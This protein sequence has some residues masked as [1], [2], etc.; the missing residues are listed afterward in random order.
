[1]CLDNL[2]T[3]TK[4]RRAPQPAQDGP[5]RR[6]LLVR[7]RGDQELAGA[8]QKGLKR[9]KSWGEGEKWKKGEKKK[10]KAAPSFF[11]IRLSSALLSY[12][13]ISL[14]PKRS[15]VRQQSHKNTHTKI[16]CKISSPLV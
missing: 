1:L 16:A 2:Q 13:R 8:G 15:Q 3:T 14:A 12:E 10:N 6:H 4:N 9:K 5:L 11:A 7:V